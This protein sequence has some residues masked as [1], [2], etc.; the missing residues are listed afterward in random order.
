MFLYW[1]VIEWT[2]MDEKDCFWSGS[3]TSLIL[4]HL[5]WA[6]KTRVML[7]HLEYYAWRSYPCDKLA[8]AVC[9]IGFKRTSMLQ[10]ECETIDRVSFFSSSARMDAFKIKL[11]GTEWLLC[12]DHVFI[13]NY[14]TSPVKNLSAQSFWLCF[15]SSG[16]VLF[17]FSFV[18]VVFCPSLSCFCPGLLHLSP[19]QDIR[20]ILTGFLCFADRIKESVNEI[21]L[22]ENV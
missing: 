21:Y 18:V 8:W 22:M 7:L 20:P 17:L 14:T 9:Q 12:R 15:V 11:N 13:Q 16:Y 3:C 1:T 6:L 10:A 5:D 4:V 19:A 2:T